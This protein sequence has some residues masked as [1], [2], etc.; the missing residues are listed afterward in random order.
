M[1][2]VFGDKGGIAIK[3]FWKNGYYFI[4]DGVD[5]VNKKVHISQAYVGNSPVKKVVIANYILGA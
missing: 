2:S 1:Y 5:L 4:I 3:S